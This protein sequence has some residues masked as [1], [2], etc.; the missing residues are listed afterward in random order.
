MTRD[1]GVR[2]PPFSP[3]P[4][5]SQPWL[6]RAIWLSLSK[7]SSRLLIF[8][9]RFFCLSFSFFLGAFQRPLAIAYRRPPPHPADHHRPL[10]PSPPFALIGRSH[11]AGRPMTAPHHHHPLANTRWP[12]P[13]D[14]PAAGARL[15]AVAACR[16][17]AG[18]PTS[19]LSA[20][21]ILRGP[22]G[23]PEGLLTGDAPACR[24]V[25]RNPLSSVHTPGAGGP[26]RG[27]SHRRRAGL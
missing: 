23:R 7:K 11:S 22:A 13:V 12:P 21:Y 6:G 25:V 19:S 20:Q 10:P 9:F 3:N 27:P 14:R 5:R 15:R 4:H 16:P 8:E 17:A 26:A 18:R 24:A 2:R 1:R